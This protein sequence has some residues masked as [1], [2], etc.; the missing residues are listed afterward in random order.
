MFDDEEETNNKE[1]VECPWCGHI[2]RDSWEWGA[3]ADSG[4]DIEC[5]ACERPISITRNVFISWS[6]R[7]IRSEEVE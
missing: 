3:D 5:G 6:A 7:K 2:E 4:L 1:G